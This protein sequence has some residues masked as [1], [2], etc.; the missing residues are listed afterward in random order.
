MYVY[1]CIYMCMCVC[2]HISDSNVLFWGLISCLYVVALK[3]LYV[4]LFGVYA[5]LPSLP[6]RVWTSLIASRA[7]MITLITERVEC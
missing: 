2:V 4:A 7:N 6:A 1:S 3:D 5:W